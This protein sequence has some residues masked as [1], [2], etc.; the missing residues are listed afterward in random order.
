MVTSSMG[1]CLCTMY[2]QCT[3]LGVHVGHLGT[4][5]TNSRGSGESVNF[6][7]GPLA[8][9]LR[10]PS[11]HL[12]TKSTAKCEDEVKMSSHTP[13][14]RFD[15]EYMTQLSSRIYMTDLAVAVVLHIELELL[16]KRVLF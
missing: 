10:S 8:G 5:S 7:L 14:E 9:F 2:T 13:T 6:P 1:L 11:R 16:V 3:V 12:N 15:S 4:V